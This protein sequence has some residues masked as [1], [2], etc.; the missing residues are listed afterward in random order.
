MRMSDAF[1]S[2]FLKAE[3]LQGRQTTVT[4]EACAFE[5]IGD[6]HKL[7]LRFVGE[8]KGLVCNKTNATMI[9]DTY[10]DETN[11]WVGKRVTLFPTKTMFGGK[12]VPCLRVMIPAAVKP[13]LAKPS[14]TPENDDGSIADEGA[15]F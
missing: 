2:N 7:V 6:D 8:E 3:D 10:G 14:E 1:P 12:Q 5:D 4:I 13:A 15:P 9:A 11:D